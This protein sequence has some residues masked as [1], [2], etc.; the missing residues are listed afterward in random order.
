MPLR[1]AAGRVLYALPPIPIPIPIAR[2]HVQ[3]TTI[4]GR[5]IH[6][7]APRRSDFA[8]QNHYQRL[9]IRH[10]ATPHEIKKYM[11]PLSAL[12]PR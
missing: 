9:G 4:S 5:A 2:L 1:L 7:S 8:T 6:T 10:D 11:H 12:N 3:T